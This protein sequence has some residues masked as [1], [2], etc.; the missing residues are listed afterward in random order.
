MSG[1]D[2]LAATAIRAAQAD[3]DDKMSAGLLSF[4]SSIAP[5]HSGHKNSSSSGGAV[6]KDRAAADGE[7]PSA[8]A[9]AAAAD[10]AAA[11]AAAARGQQKDVDVVDVLEPWNGRP[12]P[13]VSVIVSGHWYDVPAVKE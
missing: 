10:G 6:A 7:M 11:A 5:T 8:F 1:E 2:K 4:K 3:F 12:D 13:M 9:T